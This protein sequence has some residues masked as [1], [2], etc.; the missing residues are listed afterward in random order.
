MVIREVRSPET[1]PAWLPALGERPL[2]INLAWRNQQQGIRSLSFG[3]CHLRWL[4]SRSM[5]VSCAR[6]VFVNST[7]LHDKDNAPNG[8]DVF[9]WIPIERDDVRLEAGRDRADLI[10]HA[11]RFRPQ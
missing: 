7:A 5:R 2:V 6:G 4:I 10:G 9:Q 8:G 1:R 3:T 11:Q